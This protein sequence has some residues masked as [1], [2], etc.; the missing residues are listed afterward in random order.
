VAESKAKDVVE[1]TKQ[2][3]FLQNLSPF[4]IIP[5]AS[6]NLIRTAE[7]AILDS[8]KCRMCTKKVKRI[9]RLLILRRQQLLLP[10]KQVEATRGRG[11]SMSLVTDFSIKKITWNA[12]AT[13][14][15]LDLIDFRPLSGVLGHHSFAGAVTECHRKLVQNKFVTM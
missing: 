14:G 12:P 13:D 10:P 3:A 4:F 15:V 5:S 8:A 2:R 11:S 7:S 1:A 9:R 6:A